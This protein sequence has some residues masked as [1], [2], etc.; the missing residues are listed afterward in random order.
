MTPE[1]PDKDSRI[2]VHDVSYYE[3]IEKVREGACLSP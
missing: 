3:A 1:P 2:P